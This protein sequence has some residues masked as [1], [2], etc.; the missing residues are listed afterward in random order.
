MSAMQSVVLEFDDERALDEAIAHIWDKLAVFGELVRQ[1][2]PEGTF[3]LEVISEKPLQRS[4]L[5]KVGGR[6]REE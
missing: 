4:S 5:E 6:I 3:R 1:R 2:L